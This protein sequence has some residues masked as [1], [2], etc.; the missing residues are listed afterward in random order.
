[1]IKGVLSLS[2]IYTL[3]CKPLHSFQCISRRP[4]DRLA[5]ESPSVHRASDAQRIPLSKFQKGQMVA[6]K[7]ESKVVREIARQ[8][9]ISSNTVSNFIRNPESDRR[10]K[11]T[12]RPK[13]TH[14]T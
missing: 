1:M 4:K 3:W 9:R 11:K 10:K 2:S 5:S 7:N 13:K 6:Y 12:G 8:L 14:P